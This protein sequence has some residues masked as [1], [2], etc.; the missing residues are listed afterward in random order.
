V[1]E[2]ETFDVVFVCTG[3]RFRSPL[4]AAVLTDATRG[5]PVEV[6]SCGTLELGPSPA[7]T[8]AVAEAR[9][10]DLDLSAHRS[11]CLRELNLDRTDLVVG[12]ERMHVV[13][14]G[15]HAG[16]RRERVFTLPELVALVEELPAAQDPDPVVRARRLIE[17]AGRLRPSELS[18]LPELGDPLGLP[19]ALQRQTAERV[20]DLTLRLA[21]RLF[22]VRPASA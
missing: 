15:V 18:V 3:N 6:S 2:D 9:R 10:F 1:E 5:L 14:A 19:P 20:R 11:R 22:G 21:W 4:A 16:A 8:E 12:F 7:L 17:D 13:T